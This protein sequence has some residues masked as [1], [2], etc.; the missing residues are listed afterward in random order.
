MRRPFPSFPHPIVQAPMAGGPSTPELSAAVC[1]AGGFGFLAAGYKPVSTVRDELTKLRS[2]TRAPFGLNVFVPGRPS[3]NAA[4][5]DSY[6][7]RHR[8]DAAQLGVELGTPRYDD[9]A[10]SD[11]LALAIELRPMVVSF[12][13][14]CP[15]R[16]VIERLQS[17]GCA[18]WITVTDPH[19]AVLARDAGADALVVQGIEAGGHRGSFSDE[20]GVGE[21]SLLPMLRSIRR[22]VDL[23]LIAAGGIADGASIAAVLTAG[24]RAAQIG[25]GF[26]RCP[27]A[28]T[29]PAHREALTSS[30]S[31]RTAVTRA[32]T[33]RR[34]RGI[35]N[36]FMRAHSAHAPSAYPELHFA[37]APLRAKARSSGDRERLHLWAGEAFALAQ[38]RP[39]G[40]LVREWSRQARE[41]LSQA[42]QLF[43]SEN[44]SARS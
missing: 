2:L 19:E 1:N 4:A 30:E 40:D 8:D 27:E 41:A 7:A 31:K 11:K 26:L 6:L 44:A 17:V 28:G 24:A 22:V 32:F 23:P 3:T 20:D 29:S 16:D 21:V 38:A 35:E 12:V 18:V 5:V 43:G 15:E 10:W 42:L 39:A 13:F 36:A 37:T 9:D 33:G 25:T 34:A 14:G